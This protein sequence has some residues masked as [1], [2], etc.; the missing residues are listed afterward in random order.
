MW[1]RDPWGQQPVTQ[2]SKGQGLD[3]L[4]IARHQCHARVTAA[5]WKH[6][7]GV[8]LFAVRREEPDVVEA[9]YSLPVA[10]QE[11]KQCSF[12]CSET[13]TTLLTTCQYSSTVL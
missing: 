10:E 6:M 11:S 13:Q 1:Q 8:S 4:G 12:I 3:V 2:L 9:K 7:Q 5:P